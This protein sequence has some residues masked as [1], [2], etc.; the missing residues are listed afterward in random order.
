M[1]HTSGRMRRVEM[2]GASV[3]A[4]GFSEAFTSISAAEF[5]PLQLQNEVA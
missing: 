3:I 2:E 5:V 4:G 1:M